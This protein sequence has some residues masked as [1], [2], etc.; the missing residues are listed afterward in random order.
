MVLAYETLIFE[1]S[2]NSDKNCDGEG[3]MVRVA[4]KRN[5][6]AANERYV[7]EDGDD[8]FEESLVG[9]VEEL[10]LPIVSQWL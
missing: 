7:V 2:F 6:P 5:Y 1:S 4:M 9:S 8:V 10:Y 3:A